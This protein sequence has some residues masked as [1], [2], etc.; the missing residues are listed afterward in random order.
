MLLLKLTLINFESCINSYFFKMTYTSY[1]HKKG[2]MSQE[3][4]QS[5]DH[6]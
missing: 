3:L 6:G 1:F 4:K 2:N 5:S